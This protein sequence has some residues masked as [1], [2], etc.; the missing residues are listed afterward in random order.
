MIHKIHYHQSVTQ[1]S[2]S[3]EVANLNKCIL[4]R[5]MNLAKVSDWRMFSG[6]LYQG[7]GP[8]TDKARLP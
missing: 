8:D 3:L 7:A 2:S 6:K 5:V 1:N 4:R